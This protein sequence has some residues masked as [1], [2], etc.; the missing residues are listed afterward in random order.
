MKKNKEERRG[1]DIVGKEIGNRGGNDNIVRKVHGVHR[2]ERKWKI[3][4]E[5]EREEKIYKA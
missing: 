5:M 1:S 2:R 3:E 4:G